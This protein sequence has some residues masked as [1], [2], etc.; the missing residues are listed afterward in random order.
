MQGIKSSEVHDEA[1]GCPLLPFDVCLI[2]PKTR[3]IFCRE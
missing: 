3:K 1:L 2:L